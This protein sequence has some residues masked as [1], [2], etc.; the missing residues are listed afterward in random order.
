MASFFN[1]PGNIKQGFLPFC[2]DPNAPINSKFTET[3]K[4]D[5]SFSP[6]IFS[7]RPSTKTM[8]AGYPCGI[9]T[10]YPSSMKRYVR[11]DI[12]NKLTYER[13]EK[14]S[15]AFNSLM[16]EIPG[17]Q[18]REYLPDSRLDQVLNLF[19]AFADG[20]STAT[21]QKDDSGQ[22]TLESG[23][24]KAKMSK[25]GQKLYEFGQLLIKNGSDV[26]KPLLNLDGML[27]SSES[28]FLYK[29][30]DYEDAML[31]FPY[32]MYYKFI[33]STTTNIYEIPYSGRGVLKSDG[34]T[35]WDTTK[36]YA[37]A[38]TSGE[39]L[40]GKL[41]NFVGKNVA[42]NTTPM[43]SPAKGA[44]YEVKVEFDLFNDTMDSA[45]INY[46]FVNTIVP[47]NMWSQYHIYQH[48]P[49]VYDVKI[50]GSNRLYMCS[51]SFD[52]EYKG[53]LRTPSDK[54][55]ETLV[56]KHK[57]AN[58]NA[59]K[60]DVWLHNLA[61][62]P[63][64]YHLTLTFTSLLPMNFNNYLYTFSDNANVVDY[65]EANGVHVD[66]MRENFVNNNLK[67]FTEEIGK[68]WEQAGS[69]ANA[70]GQPLS[71]AGQE[72]LQ[73]AIDNGAVVGEDGDIKVPEADEL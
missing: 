67:A 61:K 18:I 72:S 62:I 31:K 63:D 50:E 6:Q 10:P 73:A 9:L 24:L 3:D 59:S 15:V 8:Y 52:C 40:L 60:K 41:L 17:I 4:F 49:C 11:E 64:I 20:W 55:L 57:N 46:I 71:K 2:L 13:G 26:V 1:I 29:K 34:T 48:N 65:V 56:E 16:E 25:F 38:G 22:T 5:K 47:N 66:S 21:S 14:T 27:N 37:F 39:S 54:F 12:G 28:Y 70:A 58:Y 42:I 43:W 7:F 32:M 51:G 19:S 33:S 44:G 45:L 35:G 68:L 69:Q 23:S 53:V 30:N 36:G